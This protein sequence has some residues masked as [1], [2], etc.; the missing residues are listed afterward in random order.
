MNARELNVALAC[1]TDAA[2]QTGRLMRQ[3]LHAAKTV[4]EA[5]HHDIKLELDVRCQALIE[6]VLRQHDPS[7]A[8]LGEEGVS[9]TVAAEARWIV[10]P[11]DGTV[12]FA[13]DVPHAC[14]CIGLQVRRAT[15]HATR[16]GKHA[17]CCADYETVLGVIYDPFNDELWTAIKGQPARMNGRAIRV[18]RRA[19]LE[20]A[21]VTF[22][23]SKSKAN[24]EKSL[25]YFAWLCRR[26]R[27]VRIMGSA[28][29]A[30]TYVA[31]GRFE[32]YVE[33][34]VRLWDIAAGGLIVEC[35]G[36]KFWCQKVG[37]FESYRLVASNGHLD[38]LLPRPK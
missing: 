2:R 1:A 38:A 8:V 36:G 4:N 37:G 23:F 28:G 9:G 31:C 26:A 3:N 25:P 29:L 34:K 24:L 12:N 27:K 30:L 32:A 7:F 35:A 21:M 14:T 13:H 33:R 17:A 22:G 5:H 19:K 15:P 11:I 10:D 18:S 16:N 6:R 20:E